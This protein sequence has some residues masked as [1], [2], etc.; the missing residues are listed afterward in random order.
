[1]RLPF[2]RPA[3]PILADDPLLSPT[4]PAAVRPPLV[5]FPVLLA[6]LL[7]LV[8]LILSSGNSLPLVWGF[9]LLILLSYVLPQRIPDGSRL[10]VTLFGLG[11]LILIA[12]NAATP[13]DGQ[14]NNYEQIGPASFRNGFAEMYA[15]LMV[16]QFW[17]WRTRTGDTRQSPLFIILFSGLVFV[18]S[19][20]T[21]DDRF[22]RFLAPIYLLCVSLALFTYRPRQSA[23]P[24]RDTSVPARFP[25]VLQLCALIV[26]F[27]FGGAVYGGVTRYRGNLTELTNRLSGYPPQ[28]M[29]MESTLM[30]EQPSLGPLFNL[31]GAPVRI[32]RINNYFGDPHW[33]GSAFDTYDKGTWGPSISDR[34]ARIIP[35]TELVP[36]QAQRVGGTESVLVTRIATDN[37]LLYFP[38]ETSE[39]DKG[40]AASLYGDVAGG[41]P[42][43][44]PR[45]TT[46]PY[47]YTATVAPSNT[48]QGVW[49]AR[50]DAARLQRALL[51]PDS[52]D[53]KIRALAQNVAGK[54]TTDAKKADAVVAYLLQ[55][56]NYSLNFV[57]NPGAYPD[58]IADFLLSQPVKGAHCEFFATAACLMLRCVGVPTRYVTGYFAHEGLGDNTTVVRQ[59]DAHAWCEAWVKGIG[60]VVVEATPAAGQPGGDNEEIEPWRKATEWIQDRLGNLSDFIANLTAVQIQAIVAVV[61]VLAGAYGT[62]TYLARKRRRAGLGI[63]ADGRTYSTPPPDVAQLAARFETVWSQKT[64]APIPAQTPYAEYVGRVFLGNEQAGGESSDLLPIAR[65]WVKDYDRARFGPPPSPSDLAALNTLLNQMEES[66]PA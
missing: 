26:A 14:Q 17:R 6:A 58:P 65:L 21:F 8:T 37:P 57:P 49:A 41:G 60:W 59:R 36:P 9:G 18:T 25:R 1:M 30:A 23:E 39:V 53:P 10:H 51:I 44:T 12:A 31:R 33:H 13:K 24:P 63:G 46:A 55:T 3:R 64:G 45:R 42:I 16:L 11:C 34:R 7:S 19:S 2:S 50:R 56:H 28:R 27:A 54:E 62:L 5:P 48:Y 20:N 32:L 15:L 22:I 40:E 43:R 38:L 29:R 35:D 52:L 61:V 66:T 47:E 4:T